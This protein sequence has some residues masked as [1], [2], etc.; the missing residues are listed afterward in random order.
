MDALMD[1]RRVTLRWVKGSVGHPENERVD[2][3]ANEQAVKAAAGTD[4]MS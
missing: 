4:A 3:L 1:G 2:G